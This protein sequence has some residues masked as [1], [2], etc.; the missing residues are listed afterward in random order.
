MSQELRDEIYKMLQR[1]QVD[2]IVGTLG[3]LTHDQVEDGEH[4]AEE[5]IWI[6]RRLAALRDA[7]LRLRLDRVARAWLG[8]QVPNADQS[9]NLM[10]AVDG[11]TRALGPA[12]EDRHIRSGDSQA[13][14]ACAEWAL[15]RWLPRTEGAD[16]IRLA[17]SLAG[18]ARRAGW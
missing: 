9:C 5:R 16:R 7:D 6:G 4:S 10:A 14:Q 15:Q 17:R 1:V 18:A 13:L 11:Y 3:V 12:W 2:D 8:N